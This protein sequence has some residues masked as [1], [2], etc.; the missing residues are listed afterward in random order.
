MNPLSVLINPVLSEKSNLERESLG[1][2]TFM[3]NNKADKA[4]VSMAVEKLFDVEVS[5][6]NMSVK[7]GK[8]KRR[9]AHTYLSKKTKKAVVTLKSGQE[10]KIFTEQ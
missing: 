4:S 10:I 5:K 2:Y 9:G 3:V 7:R 1:K 8:L 6:V